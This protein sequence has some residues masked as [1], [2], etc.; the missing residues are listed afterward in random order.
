[1]PT[2]APHGAWASPITADLVAGGAVGLTAVRQLGAD[3]HWLV[4][5]PSQ[6]GRV[7]LWGRSGAG[8]ARDLTPGHNLRSSVHEYGG[9]AVAVT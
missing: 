5:D 1:M 6:G 3:S 9:G 8:A 2:V 4:A 7:S